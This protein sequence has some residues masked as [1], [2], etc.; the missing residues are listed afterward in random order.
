MWCSTSP[1]LSLSVSPYCPSGKHTT[2][3]ATEVELCEQRLGLRYADV[4]EAVAAELARRVDDHG[5]NGGE[6]AAD[7]VDADGGQAARRHPQRW[8]AAADHHGF[9]PVRVAEVRERRG[10]RP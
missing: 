5:V 10:V 7:V 3:G 8:P 6:G 4:L 2:G 1:S 9:T